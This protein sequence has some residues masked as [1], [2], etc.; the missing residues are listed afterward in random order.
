MAD[1]S[2]RVVKGD[3]LWKIAQREL[4][5]GSQW[6][7]LY[8]YNNR[9]EVVKVTGKGIANPDLIVVGQRLLIPRID[10]AKAV[11]ASGADPAPSN[12]PEATP[13][14]GSSM[15]PEPSPQSV[16]HA[17]PSTRPTDTLSSRLPATKSPIAFKYRLD[18]LR[19]PPQDCGTAI[20]EI[21]MTGDLVLMTKKAYPATYVTSRGEIELQVTKEANTAFGRLVNDNRFVYDPLG[22]RLTFRSMLVSQSNMPGTMATAIGVEMSSNSP[23]PKLRAEFRMPKLE[24]SFGVFRYTAFDMKVVVEITPKLQG[25]PL[26]PSPQPIR[27]VDPAPQTAPAPS[28]TNW[29]KVIGTGLIVTGGIIVI[30]TVVEDFYTV[31]VGTGDDPASFA[32]ASAAVAR[33]LALMRGAVIPVAATAA[34]ISVANKVTLERA[35]R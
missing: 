15:A 31:G 4:G 25:P 35:G 7:R 16:R 14:L 24:G 34:S 10:G 6:P 5:G 29:D 17:P 28:S 2:Y 18:D 13:S 11:V 26:G 22:K 8:K 9:R 19:W 12:Q 33:G 21:R 27:R 3:S 20:V 32:A 30:A 1:N 23:I